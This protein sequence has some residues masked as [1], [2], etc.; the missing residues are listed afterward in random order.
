MTEYDISD[1]IKILE[2]ASELSIQ[3]LIN[4]LQSFLVENN[5][6][7]IGQNFSLIYQTSFKHDSF[8]DL[9]KFCTDLII[10]EPEK[11]FKSL[12]FIS[13]PEKALVSL[14]QNDNL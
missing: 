5:T 6:K 9:Q 14:I 10:G 13:I 7:W 3:E 8:S 1:V 2:A 12:D 11:I 4:Y